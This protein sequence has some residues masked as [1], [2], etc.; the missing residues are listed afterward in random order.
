MHWSDTFPL[1]PA[2]LRLDTDIAILQVVGV[3]VEC[4]KGKRNYLVD[5]HNLC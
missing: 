4:T 2:G 1:C 3:L 5:I